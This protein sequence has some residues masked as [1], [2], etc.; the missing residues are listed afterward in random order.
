MRALDLDFDRPAG[1]T[2]LGVEQTLRLWRGEEPVDVGLLV[3]E[4]EEHAPRRI[5]LQ[6]RAHHLPSGSVLSAE[7]SR[8]TL[9]TPPLLVSPTA[10][11]RLDDVLRGER[12]RLRDFAAAYGVTRLTGDSTRLYVSIRDDLA[13]GVGRG[14]VDTCLAALATVIEPTTSRG[15]LVRP[16]R[17]RLEL[18]GAYVEGRDLVG[19]LTLLVG[20]MRGLREGTAPVSPPLPRVIASR[21]PFGWF[22][23]P[24]GLQ[25]ATVLDSVWSWAR[26]WA[27]REGLDAGVV[28]D[29][30]MG[31][32]PLRFRNGT[33]PARCSFGPLQ[34]ARPGVG[35]G[36]R[37]L[38]AGI[39]AETEFRT[40]QHAV[41]V[42]RNGAGQ[43]CRAVLP[44]EQELAFLDG[45]D[46]GRFA[47]LL[48]RMLR[49]RVLRRRLV[50]NAQIGLGGWWHDV[51][52]EALVP[53][54]RRSDG[55]LPRQFTRSVRWS[56]PAQRGS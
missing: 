17:D 55:T 40:W 14:V 42:F 11:F 10:P 8:A 27:E 28:D 52:P 35:T 19:G 39:H 46:A 15:L 3:G 33:D 26:P 30:V 51:R 50:A 32:R 1:D 6:R 12:T 22:V 44:A 56:S 16:R 4:L 54:E 13:L 36:P 7:A 45:L 9:A 53:I 31:S 20:C 24:A 34:T 5:P 25:D 21:E 47:H 29:L 41:W 23:P 43:E 37:H 2:R 38:P 18:T 49:R 48:E